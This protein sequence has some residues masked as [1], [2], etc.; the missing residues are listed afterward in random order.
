MFDSLYLQYS[1]LD[2]SID[3]G[4][5]NRVFGTRNN[6]STSNYSTVVFVFHEILSSIYCMGTYIQV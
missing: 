2:S 6:H 5:V 1:F 3:F 4:D